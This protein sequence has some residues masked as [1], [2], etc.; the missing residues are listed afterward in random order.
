MGI[1]IGTKPPA[2][3]AKPPS[4]DPYPI[5]ADAPVKTLRAW[6]EPA[7]CAARTARSASSVRRRWPA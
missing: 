7:R 2:P 6:V 5:F 3:T 1:D 4:A